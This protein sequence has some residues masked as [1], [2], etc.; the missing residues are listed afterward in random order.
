MSLTGFTGRKNQ[1]QSTGNELGCVGQVENSIDDGFRLYAND[2]GKVFERDRNS[3]RRRNAL[4]GLR[5]VFTKDSTYR[6]AM[7]MNLS[8]KLDH[9][10]QTIFLNPLQTNCILRWNY[11][12][13]TVLG[14]AISCL[15][16]IDFEVR[17]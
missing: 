9:L 14:M 7:I 4:E 15:Q 8:L 1:P 12:G 17:Q 6:K 16:K 11:Y 3:P 13:T 2:R 5:D 10:M